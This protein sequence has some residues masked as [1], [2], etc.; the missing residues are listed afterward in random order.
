MAFEPGG[1]ADKLGNR[2]E[3][4]WV[5]KQLLRLLNEQICSVTIEGIGNDERGVDLFIEKKDHT[6]QYQQCKA[7]N[8]SKEFWSIADLNSK[9]ILTNAK[10]QL[11]RDPNNTF[12]LVSGVPGTVIGDICESARKS[13]DNPEDFYK[14]QIKNPSRVRHECFEQLCSYWGLDENSESDR[15][16]A[17]N[18]LRRFSILL[19]SDDQNCLDELLGTASSL[20]N[21]IP[22]TIITILSEYAQENIRKRITF[23]CVREYLEGNGFHLRTLSLDAR[24]APAIAELQKIFEDSIGPDLIGGEL[25]PREE[26]QELLKNISEKQ[27]IVLHGNAGCGKSGVLYELTRELKKTKIQ[28]LPIRLDRQVPHNTARQFGEEIGLPESPVLCLKSVLNDQGGVLIIDQ[29]DALRWTS[30]HSANSLDVCKAII[31]DAISLNYNGKA[32]SVVL[33]CRTFDLE[34][35][36][37]IK[38]WLQNQ[39]KRLNC[40]KILVKELPEKTVGTMVVKAGGN[41]AEMTAKQK[42]ILSLPQHLAMWVM[43]MQQGEVPALNSGTQLMR[44][45]WKHKYTVLRNKC[46][47]NDNEVNQVLDVLVEYMER[48]GK[49]SAPLSLISDQQNVNDALCSYGILRTDGKQV[50]FCHQSYLDFR[51]ADRL[52]RSIYQ[53]CG[54][55]IKWLGSRNEQSLFKREQLRQTLT[56]LSDETPDQF[57]TV[58]KL[59]L[60]N[61]EVR[62]HVKHLTLEVIGQVERPADSLCDYLLDLFVD[63]Y[64]KDHIK[65]TVFCGHSQYVSLL[66]DRGIAL[67]SVNSDKVE[68]RNKI[69][70]LL[71]SVA[72][73]IPDKIFDFLEPFVDKDGDWPR[74]VLGHI[75][76]NESK[77]SDKMFKLRLR[78]ISKRIV[79]HYIHWRE[80]C[81]SYPTRAIQLIEAIMSTWN[82]PRLKDNALFTGDNNSNLENWYLE[83]MQALKKV[84]A[85]CPD[86]TWDML[87]P[88]VER[89]TGIISD[90]GDADFYDWRCGHR[91]KFEEKEFPISKGVVGLLCEAG[92]QLASLKPDIFV[93]KVHQY[94]GNVS[95]VINDILICGYTVI[96]SNY[97]DNAV[98]YLLTDINRFS[99]GTGYTES[100]WMPTVRLIDAHSSYCSVPLFNSLE[101]AIVNYHSSGEKRHAEYWLTTW[102]E[103]YF[104]YYWGEAQYFLLPALSEKRR[105][106]KTNQL[107]QVLKRKFDP[108]SKKRFLKGG[109]STWGCVGS[110]IPSEKLYTL[111][112]KTWLKI[113]TNKKI[114]K[115]RG[116]KW[117][118]MGTDHVGESTVEQFAN[119]LGRASKRFPDRFAKLALKFHEDVPAEYISAILSGVRTVKPENLS[120]EEKAIWKPASCENVEAILKK[121][122]DNTRSVAHE[123]C[124]LMNYRADEKWS[125]ETITRLIDYATNHADLEPGKL[126]VY[127][128]KSSHEATVDILVQNSI[129][130]IRGIAAIAIGQILWNFPEKM[131]HLKPTLEHLSSDLHPAVR[132]ASLEACRPLLKYDKELAVKMFLNACKDD[133]RVAATRYAVEYFNCCFEEFSDRL[134]PLIINMLNSNSGEVAEEGA[135]EICARWLFH[136]YFEEE[137]ERCK[138]GTLQHRKGLA[139]VASFLIKKEEYADKCKNLLSLFYNDENTEV[140]EKA[141]QAYHNNPEIL[142]VSNINQTIFDFVKSQAF[143]DRPTGIIYTFKKFTGTLL[144]YA[145]H[146]FFICEEL[147]KCFKEAPGDFIQRFSHDVS[148]LSSLVLRL[149]EQGKDK[150]EISSKCLDMWDMLFENRISNVRELTK[151]IET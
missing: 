148:M 51:I 9:D 98:K 55:V 82:S 123:F 94:Q 141:S 90:S 143:R 87:M 3:G 150:E 80:L 7:R 118:Q 101:N 63:D 149:Y 66:L 107:I 74:L 13:N 57:L 78:L 11:D 75:G 67:Q 27:L 102:K 20:I 86:Y 8:A 109:S 93:Q 122:P 32:I 59:I 60:S 65:E 88:H 120:E 115:G 127:C 14:Y 64:W 125:G 12:A 129:N 43:I 142:K 15:A 35:D 36:P 103:G 39:S 56:L 105:S 30:S 31:R 52:L 134:S 146:M 111:S 37:E 145:A 147:T 24:V 84:A 16:I 136:G 29:L 44:E 113:I 91:F 117:K 46:K 110:T 23:D 104:G 1:Y 106:S 33:S 108:Y 28:Y 121:F 144:P 58:I 139:E 48:E 21:G 5:V 138:V 10:F 124:W 151:A 92:K 112:D 97:S 137:L 131:E 53:G 4:R 70:W 99:S 54:D 61:K 77:D 81:K 89:L 22:N 72:E 19:W 69:L 45:F 40:Q 133:L 2:Y 79:K 119:D 128:D 38:K 49:I 26:T 62:F 96:S 34:H 114:I 68:E 42:R 85:D 50:I 116:C 130:C 25:I 41:F 100:E 83:D 76:W 17:F 6:I 140:R 47:I 135:K 132:I 18:Y 126:N 71:S 95:T 73:F